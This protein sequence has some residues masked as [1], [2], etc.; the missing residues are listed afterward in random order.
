M[1]DLLIIRLN[2]IELFTEEVDPP[3]VFSSCNI[4]CLVNWDERVRIVINY[5]ANGDEGSFF[6]RGS[7]RAEVCQANLTFCLVT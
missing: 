2:R 7:S 5:L 3:A 6:E 4:N 1:I